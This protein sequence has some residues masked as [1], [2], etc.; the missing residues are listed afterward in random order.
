MED[1]FLTASNI[2][3]FVI[4]ISALGFHTF[5]IYLLCKLRENR[6]NQQLILLNLSVDELLY[7]IFDIIISILRF[8]GIS[9]KNEILRTLDMMTNA[10][11]ILQRLFMI[12]IALDRFLAAKLGLKYSVQFSKRRAIVVLICVWLVGLSFLLPLL[13]VPPGHRNNVLKYVYPT[14]DGLVVVCA[15]FTYIYIAKKLNG[16]G[17]SEARRASGEENKQVPAPI[18]RLFKMASLII[19]SFIIL[20][21]IPD[22]IY[23]VVIVLLK[24]DMIILIKILVILWHVNLSADAVIYIFL[25]RRVREQFFRMISFW[26][27]NRNND[28]GGNTRNNGTEYQIRSPAL[29]SRSRLILDTS[30]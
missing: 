6:T 1:I 8:S 26:R 14:L 29:I 18:K 12:L 21:A 16:S 17:I 22:T 5:G 30:L 25:Q 11:Y 7:A 2:L 13:L 27:K 3:S 9:Y 15:L 23:L 28:E 24:K 4:L 19:A 20:V 10:F